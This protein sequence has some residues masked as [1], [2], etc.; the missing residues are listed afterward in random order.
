MEH[1]LLKHQSKNG[2]VTAG[3]ERHSVKTDGGTA[4]ELLRSNRR[5]LLL[6]GC[7]PGRYDTRMEKRVADAPK[8]GER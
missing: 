8:A 5:H 3:V 6:S 1:E 4:T 2:E 7:A